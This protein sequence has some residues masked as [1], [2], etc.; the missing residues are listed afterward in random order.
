LGTHGTYGGLLKVTTLLAMIDLRTQAIK[1]F[2]VVYFQ[3]G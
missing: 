1:L 2:N 3:P